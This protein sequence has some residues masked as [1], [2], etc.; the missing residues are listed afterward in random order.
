MKDE[1]TTNSHYLTYTSLLKRLGECSFWTW[2]ANTGR[3]LCQL[4]G[5]APSCFVSGRSS[6]DQRS[7]MLPLWPCAVVLFYW[8][9]FA[10]IHPAIDLYLFRVFTILDQPIQ[11]EFSSGRLRFWESRGIFFPA[12]KPVSHS[13]WIGWRRASACNIAKCDN[14]CRVISPSGSIIVSSHNTYN[15]TKE[16]ISHPDTWKVLIFDSS[17]HWH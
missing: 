8:K 15:I 16:F 1:Y 11:M 7:T 6:S 17:L 5:K 9:L 4:C 2:R 14:N 10:V 12:C 13:N 3:V